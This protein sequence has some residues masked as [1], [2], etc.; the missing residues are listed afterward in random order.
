[1]A[2]FTHKVDVSK[3]AAQLTVAMRFAFILAQKFNHYGSRQ[4]DI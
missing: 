1:M 3:N 4:A 2:L